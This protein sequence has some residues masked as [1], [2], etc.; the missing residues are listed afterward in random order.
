[1]YMSTELCVVL[2]VGSVFLC[3]VISWISGSR[4]E[5]SY[6]RKDNG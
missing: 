2:S 4:I 1:M 5:K 6:K 3:M